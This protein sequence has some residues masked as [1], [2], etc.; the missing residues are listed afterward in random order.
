MAIKT[1]TMKST[2]NKPSKELRALYTLAMVNVGIYTIG[3][4]ALV[5]LLQ[6]GGNIKGM[7]VILASGIAVGIQ[8]IA[9]ISKLQ[10]N[11]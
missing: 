6:K 1:I 7:Y 11:P 3:L 4:I 2:K 10:K 8:L 9:L 5:I